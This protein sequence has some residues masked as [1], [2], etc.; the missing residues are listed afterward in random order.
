MSFQ[1]PNLRHGTQKAKFIFLISFLSLICA[2]SLTYPDSTLLY[3]SHR[4]HLISLEAVLLLTHGLFY[5]LFVSIFGQLCPCS[6]SW[7]PFLKQSASDRTHGSAS[8][9]H[10]KV[11]PFLSHLSTLILGNRLIQGVVKESFKTSKHNIALKV[12]MSRFA[13]IIQFI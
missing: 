2:F 7:L 11:Q 5:W 6:M 1:H 12:W 13:P 4:P 8:L 10:L 9:P 3:D